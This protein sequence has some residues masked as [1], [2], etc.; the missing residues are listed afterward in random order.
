MR[1]HWTGTKFC[2]NI[3]ES[4]RSLCDDLYNGTENIFEV[5]KDYMYWLKGY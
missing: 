5:W 1:S 4:Y 3:S 2:Q